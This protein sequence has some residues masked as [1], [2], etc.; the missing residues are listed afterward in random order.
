MISLTDIEL[1]M[2]DAEH[3]ADRLR[4][5]LR[6][7]RRRAVELPETAALL[8]TTERQI[9]RLG[10]TRRAMR[11]AIDKLCETIT[12][13]ACR[14]WPHDREERRLLDLLGCEEFDG[15]RWPYV[16]TSLRAREEPTVESI[17]TFFRARQALWM[18]R[19]AA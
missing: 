15:E 4:D 1:D 10:D 14:G 9:E 6:A 11:A 8:A 18:Q 3:H 19:R 2:H 17:K 12:F 13:R 7:A 5:V 16:A